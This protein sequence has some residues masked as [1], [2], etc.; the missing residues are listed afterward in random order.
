MLDSVV[1]EKLFVGVRIFGVVKVGD[2]H[3]FRVPK[4]WGLTSDGTPEISESDEDAYYEKIDVSEYASL[5]AIDGKTSY[6][7][8]MCLLYR[9][10]RLFDTA[11]LTTPTACEYPQDARRMYGVVGFANIPE[12]QD[13]VHLNCLLA[14]HFKEGDALIVICSAG[15]DTNSAHEELYESDDK[16]E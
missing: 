8:S 9:D 13:L 6:A 2:V 11:R 5:A 10:G 16:A 12:Y 14:E 4:S 1:V 15:P 7:D 3:M